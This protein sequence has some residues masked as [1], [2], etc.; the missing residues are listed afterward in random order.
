MNNRIK[1]L[2]LSIVMLMPALASAEGKIAVLSAQQAIINT[3]EAQERLKALRKDS[4][5]AENLKQLE[6]L[7]KGHDEAVAQLQKDLAIMSPEQKQAEGKKIQE[8]R[9]DIEHVAR[10]LQAAEQELLQ[11]IAQEMAPKLQKAVA[12]IIK[13]EGIGLLIDRKAAMHVDNSYSITAKVTDKLNQ[14]K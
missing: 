8:K 12:E 14:S 7:K 6:A 2:I 5:Y 1:A 10:K 9:A 11:A 3:D 4:S 13:T